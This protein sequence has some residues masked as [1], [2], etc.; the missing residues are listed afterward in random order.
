MDTNTNTTT[1]SRAVSVA[2]RADPG[3]DPRA[4]ARAAIGATRLSSAAAALT[5]QV[6]AATRQRIEAQRTDARRVDPLDARE[7]MMRDARLVGDAERGLPAAVVESMV[8]GVSACA[9]ISESGRCSP[10]DAGLPNSYARKAFFVATSGHEFRVSPTWARDVRDAGLA[11]AGGMLTLGAARL[12]VI[13]P[14]AQ[15]VWT[16]AWARQGR[17]TSLVTERGVIA[18]LADGSY[19]HARDVAHARKLARAR[20]GAAQAARADAAARRASKAAARC[21]GLAAWSAA[22]L[23]A[24]ITAESSV[25]A[26]NC[27]TGTADWI[28]RHL[29][30]VVEATVGEVLQ[31]AF[32]TGDRVSSAVAACLVAIRHARRKAA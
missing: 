19:V 9:A 16:A 8:G 20:S 14:G 15:A 18:L 32:S 1:I 29:P 26:G 21:A 10:R 22:E 25:A 2:L 7:R 13:V 5:D 27:E 28:A 24:P 23:A 30:G 31:A 12:D 4:V 17:G 6:A 11:C 3:A